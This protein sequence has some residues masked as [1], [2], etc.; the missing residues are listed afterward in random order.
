MLAAFGLQALSLSPIMSFLTAKPSPFLS[1]YVK[2]F[3]MIENVLPEGQI[4]TQRI[5]P[6]GLP[7]MMFYFGDLPDTEES[8]KSITE[9]SIVSGQQNSFYDLEISKTL[10]LFSV[11]FLP[12]GLATFFNLPADEVFD[13]NTPLKYL[14]KDYTEKLE[15][16]LFH[17]KSFEQK[18]EIM[19]RFLF[20]IITKREAKYDEN[21]IVR[22]IDLINNSK[23]NI[24]IESL[25]DAACLS[26]KQFERTF[27]NIIGIS[28]K[29][30]LR[31][32]RFQHAIDIKAKE[33]DLSLSNL[34]YDCGYFDQSHMI[35]DFRK[36]S[37]ISPKKFFDD[38][39]AY[40]DYFGI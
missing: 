27:S 33:P 4:H 36:L 11:S 30:F 12:F 15:S 29:K 24:K 2:T 5:V 37:G 19:E 7:E 25:A 1:G 10:S 38:C 31:I 26:R 39:D 32:V 9:R 17:A 35:N 14:I 21:R 28:P 34:T 3:W 40:S 20:S 18:V 8:G 13:Y 6:N 16:D 23:G 22:S